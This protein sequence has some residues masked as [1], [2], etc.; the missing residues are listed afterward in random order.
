VSFYVVRYLGPERFGVLS[1][2]LSFV[3][4]FTAISALG[5]DGVVVRNLVEKPEQKDVILGAAFFL[6]ILG[7][8]IM[9]LSILMVIPFTNNDYSTN[10]L[11]AII[12]FSAIFQSLN[13]IDFFNQATVQARYTVKAQLLQLI[14]SSTLQIVFVLKSAPLIWFA[15]V[16]VFDAAILALGLLVGYELRNKKLFK[17]RL[18]FV[19]ARK[20]MADSWP[21]VFAGVVVSVYMKIDQVMIKEML[22]TQ[23]VGYYA[24]AVKLSEAWYFIPMAICSSLFPAVV[25][26][27]NND[28]QLFIKRIKLL[29]F[30]VFWL[31]FVVALPVTFISPWIIDSFYGNTFEQ[32]A[33]VLRIHIWAGL[34][35]ALGV[36]SSSWLLSEN[37]QKLSLYRTLIGSIINIGL[38]IILIPLYGIEGAALATLISY[39]VATFTLVFFKQS[40]QHSWVMIKAVLKDF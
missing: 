6:K 23:A 27:K 13:V 26:A 32:S 20:L 2:A 28:Q 12:A 1:Y 25:E 4:L 5:L 10:I 18:S 22:D 34:F 40:R 7:A 16:Y 14:V 9:W 29:Y 11:V 36:A 8:L 3:G 17:W 24:A 31:A 38:N 30:T 19:E 15:W 39:A 35:V 37:L 33:D 21:L